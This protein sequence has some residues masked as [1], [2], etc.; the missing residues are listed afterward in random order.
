M[1][2]LRFLSVSVCVFSLFLLSSSAQTAPASPGQQTAQQQPGD[3]LNKA[4][5]LQQQAEVKRQLRTQVSR[6]NIADQ[7]APKAFAGDPGIIANNWST[8]PNDPHLRTMCGAI[9]SYNFSP[10]SNPQL[11]SV[12]TCTPA[13]TVLTRRAHKQRFKKPMMPGLVLVDLSSKR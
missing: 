7:D 1:R 9:V 13:N 10:G 6:R 4:Y 11:E 12:T 2:L 3:F 5:L 8:N